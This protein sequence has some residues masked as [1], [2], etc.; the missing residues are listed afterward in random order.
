MKESREALQE[1]LTFMLLLEEHGVMFN[2][3]IKEKNMYYQVVKKIKKS[4]NSKK[5]ESGKFGSRAVTRK[6]TTD[7]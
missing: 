1:A 2:W 4:L 6:V 7:K 3:S 5:N